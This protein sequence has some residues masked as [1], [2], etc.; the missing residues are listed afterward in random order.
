MA[1]ENDNLP[2]IQ[3]EESNPDTNTNAKHFSKL[4]PLVL[5]VLGVLWVGFIY[6]IFNDNTEIR[7]PKEDVRFSN[8]TPKLHSFVAALLLKLF[9]YIFFMSIYFNLEKKLINACLDLSRP[10]L[11]SSSTAT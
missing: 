5:V 2:F 7:I 6:N 1:N 11:S 4:I 8:C 3:I 9:L 10:N